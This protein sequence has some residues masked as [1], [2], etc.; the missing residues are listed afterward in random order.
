[1]QFYSYNGIAP[2]QAA[3][4]ATVTTGTAL[5]TMLQ[6]A[7]A[8]ARP[9]RVRA[10]G[11]FFDGSAAGVPIKCN[12]L[13]TSAAATVTAHVAAG[14]MPYD[15]EAGVTPS[16]VQLGTALSGYT[17]SAEG[18]YTSRVGDS[19]L[20]A[21]SAGYVYEWP[22]GKEFAVPVSRFLRITVTAAVAVNCLCWVRW[23]E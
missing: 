1:M 20:V 8:A 16:T 5:K 14:V 6:I 17:A 11:V 3:A 15:T 2:T 18:T 9:I 4:I 12:L 10:W 7:T 22:L 13:D 23:E 21:P 19:A